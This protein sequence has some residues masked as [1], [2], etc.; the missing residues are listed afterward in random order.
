V[1]VTRETGE[2]DAGHQAT[3]VMKGQGSLGRRETKTEEQGSVDDILF[4]KGDVLH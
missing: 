1:L 4:P 2:R 3:E